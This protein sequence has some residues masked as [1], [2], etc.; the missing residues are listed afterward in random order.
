MNIS[1]I[2]CIEMNFKPNKISIVSGTGES[3]SQLNAYDRALQKAGIGDLNLITVSSILP[4]NCEI[5]EKPEIPQGAFVPSVI[6]KETSIKTEVI[7]AAI[8]VAECEEGIGLICEHSSPTI[9]KATVN[10]TIKMVKEMAKDR[11]KKIKKIHIKSEQTI[12]QNC[13]AAIAAAVFWP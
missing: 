13:G 4:E 12:P 5:V 7:S 10:K 1:L 2:N 3:D 11:N 6:A 9:E 8:A